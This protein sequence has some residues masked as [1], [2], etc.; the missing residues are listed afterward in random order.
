[1]KPKD[2]AFTTP[3]L[4]LRAKQLG[5]SV[6]ELNLLSFGFLMDLLTEQGNDNFE[7]PDK[8]TQEDIDSFF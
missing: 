1:M 6:A 3:L 7:Y 2:R 5:L 8:A 4:L